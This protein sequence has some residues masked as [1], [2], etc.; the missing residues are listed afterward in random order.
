MDSSRWRQQFVTGTV[1]LNI[2]EGH[3]ERDTSRV[4]PFS[5][6]RADFGQLHGWAATT[7]KDAEGFHQSF[8]AARDGAAVAKGQKEVKTSRRGTARAVPD[9]PTISK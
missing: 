9:P 2:V 6:Y 1:G 8:R 5:L 3:A 7:R 4:S